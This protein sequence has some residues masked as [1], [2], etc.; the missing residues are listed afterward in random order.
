LRGL[1]VAV[2]VVAAGGSGART[3]DDDDVDDDDDDD[4]GPKSSSTTFQTGLLGLLNLRLA[5]STS[6]TSSC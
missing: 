6:T 4:A 2:P 1:N 5:S 3:T